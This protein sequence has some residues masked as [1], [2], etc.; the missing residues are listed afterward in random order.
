[1]RILL[2]TPRSEFPGVTPG[3]MKIPQMSLLI[4]AE[5]TPPAHEVKIVDEE[6]EP[7]PW[8]E[9]WDVV[10]ISLMTA[11]ANRGYRL[12]LKFRHS[13]AKVILGG[14]HPS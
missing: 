13:G 4:L 5:L 1:M 11:T 8:S 10:G 7:I 12:A 3:W 14:V 9:A 6:I 2:I